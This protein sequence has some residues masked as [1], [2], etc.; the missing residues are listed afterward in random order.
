MRNTHLSPSFSPDVFPSLATRGLSGA[1]VQL[2]HLKLMSVEIDDNT[3]VNSYVQWRFCY[4]L[5]MYIEFMFTN[6]II[7]IYIRIQVA[8]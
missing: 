8:S 6:N 7:V 2:L 1:Q 5:H 3:V 4:Y